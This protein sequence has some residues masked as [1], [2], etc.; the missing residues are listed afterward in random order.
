M[1]ISPNCREF[2]VRLAPDFILVLDEVHSK[3]GNQSPLSLAAHF[4]V[5]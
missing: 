3:D 2:A 1:E 5:V 4:G